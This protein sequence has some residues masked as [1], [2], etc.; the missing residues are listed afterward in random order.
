MTRF[1]GDVRLGMKY[2]TVGEVTT[3]DGRPMRLEVVWIIVGTGAPI[4]VTAYPAC[5]VVP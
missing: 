5:G 2:I 3:A 1:R 4:L